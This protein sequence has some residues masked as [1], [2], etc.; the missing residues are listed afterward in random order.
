MN[1]AKFSEKPFQRKFTERIRAAA[2][3]IYKNILLLNP[4]IPKATFLYP[5]NGFK[6]LAILKRQFTGD[7]LW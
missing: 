1:L 4:F 7:I 3:D 5:K 2:F 6:Q